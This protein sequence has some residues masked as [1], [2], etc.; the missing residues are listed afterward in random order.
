MVRVNIII[1]AA[2][3]DS[4]ADALENYVVPKIREE[5]REGY[6]HGEDGERHYFEMQEYNV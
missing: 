1:H 5:Y 6:E 2:D 4:A 3:A